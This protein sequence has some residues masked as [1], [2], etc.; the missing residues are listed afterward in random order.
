M[1]AHHAKVYQGP[2]V[3][4]I[5]SLTSLLVVKMLTVLVTTISNSKGIFTEKDVSSFCKCNSYSHFVSK[6]ISIYTI[7]YDQSFNDMLTNDVSFEPL[8][9]EVFSLSYSTQ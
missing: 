2:V 3:Q 4:S 9:S 7:F 8:G 1:Q 6:N 5:V